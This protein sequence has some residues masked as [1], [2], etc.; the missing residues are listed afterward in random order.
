MVVLWI[1]EHDIQRFD[2][3]EPVLPEPPFLVVRGF[4]IQVQSCAKAVLPGHVDGIVENAFVLSGQSA[5]DESMVTG[6]PMPVTK[7]AGD[8]VIGAAVNTTGSLRMRAAKVGAD[9]MLAQ[10]IRMVQSVQASKPRSS[11]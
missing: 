3:F 10:I 2:Q 7:H 4:I 6:E 8:T 1:G 5:V 9:T 11:G